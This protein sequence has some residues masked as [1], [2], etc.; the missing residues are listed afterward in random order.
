VGVPSSD[1]RVTLVSLELLES[2]IDEDDCEFD[3]SGNCQAHGYTLS[4]GEKCPQQELKEL[5]SY[6]N[7]PKEVTTKDEALRCR[8]SKSQLRLVDQVV[9]KEQGK[10]NRKVNRSSVVRDALNE[11]L[12]AVEAEYPEIKNIVI[13]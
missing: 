3:H 6:L 11:Y 9:A 4:P 8:I 5:L 2:F 1:T 10:G 13:N 12:D 7:N